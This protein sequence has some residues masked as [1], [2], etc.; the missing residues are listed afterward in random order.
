[1]PWPHILPAH[2]PHGQSA[3]TRSGAWG[4]VLYVCHLIRPGDPAKEFSW[5]HHLC[6]TDRDTEGQRFANC[7]DPCLSPTYLLLP[8]LPPVTLPCPSR[9]FGQV[10]IPVWKY[11]P[12]DLD[13]LSKIAA[14]LPRNHRE[15]HGGC[16]GPVFVARITSHEREESLVQRCA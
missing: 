2:V 7:P 4:P 14:H 10:V 6:V 16:S 1:M 15:S 11:L 9:L 13:F 8:P 12:P 5:Y 3:F